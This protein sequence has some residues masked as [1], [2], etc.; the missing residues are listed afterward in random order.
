MTVERNDFVIGNSWGK[1][2]GT[3]GPEHY[4]LYL[5]GAEQGIWRSI[6]GAHTLEQTDSFASIPA[7][8]LTYETNPLNADRCP[9]C[10]AA[11]LETDIGKRFGLS[12][13][14]VVGKGTL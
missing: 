8:G 13:L 12:R 14:V 2:A 3:K 6:C 10:E 4:W 5:T 11:F 9:L 1:P 7:I